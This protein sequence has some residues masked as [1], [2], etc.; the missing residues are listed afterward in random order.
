MKMEQP[1]L[2]VSLHQPT[3]QALTE[4]FHDIPNVTY[5]SSNIRDINFNPGTMFMSPANCL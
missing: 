2:F 1:I 5:S 4:A 3:I